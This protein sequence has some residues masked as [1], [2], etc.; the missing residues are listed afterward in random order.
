MPV[1]SSP[2]SLTDSCDA[3]APLDVACEAT[4]DLQ[5]A[6]TACDE[7]RRFASTPPDS[8][9]TPDSAPF[10]SAR[11]PVA[12]DIAPIVTDEPLSEP[13]PPSPPLSLASSI[14]SRPSSTVFDEPAL[15]LPETCA[16]PRS[17]AYRIKVDALEAWLVLNFVRLPT[18]TAHAAARTHGLARINMEESYELALDIAWNAT[19]FQEEEPDRVARLRSRVMRMM[20]D[21]L[22]HSQ[23]CKKRRALA[24]ARPKLQHTPKLYSFPSTSTS[25]SF[26]SLSELRQELDLPLPPSLTRRRRF[27]TYR[28]SYRS[29]RSRSRS[30]SRSSTQ[31]H[32]SRPQQ[33]DLQMRVRLN[34]A[35]KVYRQ[36][37]PQRLEKLRKNQELA[38][39]YQE[40]ATMA[41]PEE[42]QASTLDDRVGVANLPQETA[43][44]CSDWRLALDEDDDEYFAAPPVF[45]S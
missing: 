28:S 15:A 20:D 31:S 30:R 45:D 7:G 27:A 26:V 25:P 36:N 4:A 44:V 24:H 39:R 14:A 34:E 29:H 2:N 12:L 40:A 1:Y 11:S 23:N 42:T 35:W 3:L 6:V 10:A 18:G 21:Y 22:D 37:E 17:F 38:R 41:G 33:S 5:L 32:R 19:K 43:V 9:F 8:L 16:L 13:S